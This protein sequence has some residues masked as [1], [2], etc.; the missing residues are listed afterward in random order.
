M[1][2]PGLYIIAGPNG[3]G[4][5]TLSGILVAPGTFVFD[6]DKELDRLQKQF[7][8]IDSATLF[9]SVNDR[10]FEEK[11]AEAIATKSDFALETNFRSE[12]L[13]ETV[14]QFKD[15]G[16][17]INLIYLGLPS[18]NHAKER[19]DERVN[20]GGHAVSDEDIKENYTAGLANLQQY[21]SHFDSVTLLH[22]SIPAHRQYRV[23]T[24]AVI[25]GGKIEKQSSKLPRW[26]QDFMLARMKLT[27]KQKAVRE[28]LLPKKR[29][30]RSRGKKL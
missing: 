2:T 26:A 25:K 19:V 5:S 4:K 8:D 15:N 17:Q 12:K 22:N 10:I 7:P 1:K 20:N 29:Q 18:V 24:L 3:A 30:G 21:H 28:T 9:D 6:G 14:K 16:Y 11:K 23:L 13:M 27:N